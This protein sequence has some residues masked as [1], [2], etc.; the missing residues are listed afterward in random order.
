MQSI[1]KNELFRNTTVS[2]I[3]NTVREIKYNRGIGEELIID[4]EHEVGE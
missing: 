1:E 3:N 2:D 4:D